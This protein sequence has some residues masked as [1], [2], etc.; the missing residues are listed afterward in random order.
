MMFYRNLFLL[1]ILIFASFGAYTQEIHV[2][3]DVGFWV[4]ANFNK[5]FFKDF[6]FSS[7]YQIRTFKDGSEID[8]HIV[9]LGI[10][11]RINNRY[12]IGSNIRYI[13]DK[14]RDLSNS[15][16]ELTS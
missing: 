5:D 7:E 12:V 15:I 14:K 1:I 4:G 6:N 2:E 8:D 10:T 13:Y 16:K 3:K 11:Q 9:D